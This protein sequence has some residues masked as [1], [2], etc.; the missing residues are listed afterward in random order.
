MKCWV[1]VK[2][3]DIV[4]IAVDFLGFACNFHVDMVDFV[5]YALHIVDSIH[6]VEDVDVAFVDVVDDVVDAGVDAVYIVDCHVVRIV[7]AVDI[8][9]V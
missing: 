8:F 7:V 4:D 3:F 5:V 2:N 1:A 9:D 6:V